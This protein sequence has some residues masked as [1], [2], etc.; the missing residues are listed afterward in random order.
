M[1]QFL[2]RTG[3]ALLLCPALCLPVSAQ[4]P[5]WGWVQKSGAA[6]DSETATGIARDPSG[7][8]YVTGYF[9][10]TI[11]IGATNLVSSGGRDIFIAKYSPSGLLLW[12]HK[13]GGTGN[14]EASGIAIDAVGNCVVTGQIQGAA[15]FGSLPASGSATVSAS[16][17]SDVFVASYNGA[18]SL[19]WVNNFGG[20]TGNQVAGQGIATDAGG[21][22]YFTGYFSGAGA[23][24]FGPYSLAATGLNSDVFVAKLN[25]SGVLQW[26]VKAGGNGKD[27]ARA[28]VTD[29]A[30]NSCVTGLFRGTATFGTSNLVS[31][32]AT[33]DDVFMAKYNA[34][35]RLPG[36]KMPL[37]APTTNL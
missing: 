33:H 2:L 31:A 6:S 21:N 8:S 11:T 25:N 13:A 12:A 24:V 16:G 10:G 15:T 30:G 35:E 37:A 26:A 34:A 29:A 22:S 27:F 14:D 5:G 28:I 4:V 32:A 23:V 36:C 3:L 20:S 1:N 9:E 19:Q 17:T 7:N 18:G